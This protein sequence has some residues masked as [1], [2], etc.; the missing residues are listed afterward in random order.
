MMLRLPINLWL[1]AL[2]LAGAVSEGSA[3]EAPPA[4][5]HEAA[6][7]GKPWVRGGNGSPQADGPGLPGQSL[8]NSGKPRPEDVDEGWTWLLI[9]LGKPPKD[10]PDDPP[11]AIALPPLVKGGLGVTA[12]H[13]PTLEAT[14]CDQAG[15]TACEADDWGYGPVVFVEV[16]PLRI[17]VS[18]GLR[19]GYT[20]VSVNQSYTGPGL[21]DSSTIDLDI[22]SATLYATGSLTVA[23]R[24]SLF[25]TLGALWAWNR[26]TVTSVFADRR[27]QEERSES[28]L[29]F[30]IGAGLEQMIANRT[31][32][33]L[34]YRFINGDSGD[35]DRQHEIGL[36]VG[37]G[38]VP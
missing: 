21:P 31:C 2:L 5:H 25:G 1:F 29:R 36:S 34:E 12:S 33:R 3:Q 14:A 19:G 6:N 28:G 30:S 11:V 26:A 22:W 10:D 4:P 7:R 24:T 35:A 38:L 8:L 13:F 23:E 32:L 18:I 27:L 17:P 15:I 9:N 16:N 37:Y 20:S